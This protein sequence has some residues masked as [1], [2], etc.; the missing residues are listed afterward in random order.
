MYLNIRSLL[1]TQCA[2][3]K[4]SNQKGKLEIVSVQD[5]DEFTFTS[6][7]C[8]NKDIYFLWSFIESERVGG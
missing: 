4:Q 3:L 8:S 2:A 5:E 6:L 7:K 1:Y